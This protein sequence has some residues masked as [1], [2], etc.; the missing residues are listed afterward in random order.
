MD[1]LP[2][3]FEVVRD[4]IRDAVP[5]AVS[6]QEEGDG[7]PRARSA[8]SSAPAAV[9]GG[10]AFTPDYVDVRED[11]V[12]IFGRA[13]ASVQAFTYRI[14][15][16]NQGT[17]AVPPVFGESM[18]DRGVQARGLGAKITVEKP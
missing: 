9:S 15:A 16:I 10:A 11:R 5:T 1:L 6:N 17:Y 4:S 12:V 3:G 14:K 13:D 7:D 18:Y 2:G 8:Q